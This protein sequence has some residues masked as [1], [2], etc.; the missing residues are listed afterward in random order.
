MKSK[1]KNKRE[2]LREKNVYW[3]EAQGRIKK[4]KDW[5]RTDKG[6]EI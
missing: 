6:E 4:S 2:N 1:G 3:T 5:S